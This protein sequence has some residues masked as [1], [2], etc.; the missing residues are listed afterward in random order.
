L[1]NDSDVRSDIVL[2]A[3]CTTNDSNH[4]S[5]PSRTGEELAKAVNQALSRS[6]MNWEEIGFVSAHGTATMYNDEME[7]KALE[8]LGKKDVPVFSLKGSI[9]HTLGAAGLVEC[10]V[11]IMALNDEKTPPTVGYDDS[12]ISDS[13]S[14]SNKSMALK[15]KR[16]FI[17]T[18]SGF[19]GL[20]SVIVIGKNK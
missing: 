4:I 20:N 10:I 8:L 16:G 15:T 14:V 6:S 3:G 2:S 11:G 17:K 12:P 7:I 5:A 1:S 9:G 13:V 18:S 19:G